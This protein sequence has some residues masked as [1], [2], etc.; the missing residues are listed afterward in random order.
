MNRL[1]PEKGDILLFFA[2]K[3]ECPLFLGQRGWSYVEVL[4]ATVLLALALVPALEATQTALLGAAVH[5]QH[6][7][8]RHRLSARV[9][10]LL[11]QPFVDLDAAATAAG[12][13]TVATTYS[14]G[15][16]TASR[17]LVFLS[18]YDG[19]NAD[20]DNDP[21]TGTDPGLLWI[22]VEIE[23]TVIA[24]ETLINE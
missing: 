16:G 7:T 8:D 9:E 15:V 11:A 3:A 5:E 10:E 2:K 19:D 6:A 21:F 17:R 1:P 4:I 24:L 23:N 14:D 22:K 12:G 18:P 13:P 20:A